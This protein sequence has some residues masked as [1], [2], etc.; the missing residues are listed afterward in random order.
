[1]VRKLEEEKCYENLQ[2][3]TIT[4]IF[5]LPKVREFELAAKRFYF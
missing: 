2:Q 1:M 5:T 4:T 3:A